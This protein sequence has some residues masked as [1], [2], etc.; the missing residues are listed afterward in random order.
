MQESTKVIR[1]FVI[2]NLVQLIDELFDQVGKIGSLFALIEVLIVYTFRS[3]NL[4]R[5]R[6]QFARDLLKQ[7]VEHGH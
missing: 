7:Q 1:H 2:S 3:T 6:F 5:E 4:E